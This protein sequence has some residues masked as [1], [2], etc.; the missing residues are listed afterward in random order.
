MCI[1][2]DDD[3]NDVSTNSV[4]NE[5]I[6]SGLMVYGD[7]GRLENHMRSFEQHH[8]GEEQRPSV[9]GTHVQLANTWVTDASK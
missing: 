7:N 1:H 8:V 3:T 6:L 4:E 9:D 5:Y 2:G